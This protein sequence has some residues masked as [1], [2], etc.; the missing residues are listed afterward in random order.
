MPALNYAESNPTPSHPVGFDPWTDERNRIAEEHLPQIR[1]IA[2]MIGS[3]YQPNVDLDDLV[4]AG[5]IGLLDALE[6]FDAKKGIQFKTY[7]E[8]RIRGAMLDRLRDLDPVPKWLRQRGRQLEQAYCRLEHRLGRAATQEE[9]SAELGI[10]LRDLQELLHRL[11]TRDVRVGDAPVEPDDA[12]DAMSHVPTET[13]SP[14]AECLRGEVRD[15][16]QQ[17]IDLLPEREQLVL[18]LRYEQDMSMKDIG[19]ILGVHQSRVSQ[20]HNKA[21][22]ELRTSIPSRL[23][24]LRHACA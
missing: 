13:P 16:L 15:F 8:F 21:I 23:G 2:R 14:F 4:S 5:F 3:R 11:R 10:E 9:V 22:R 20:L 12:W 18:S 1:Y 6:K 17:A 7:A 19:A 24:T